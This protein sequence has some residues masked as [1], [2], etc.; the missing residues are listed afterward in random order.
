MESD[1]WTTSM[2]SSSV[3]VRRLGIGHL[4]AVE[5]V[6]GAGLEPAWVSPED[7]R[8]T[9]AFAARSLGSWSGLC[10]HRIAYRDVGAPRPVSTPSGP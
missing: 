5:E 7:F 8:T 10:L 2:N 4:P 3:H 1:D 9:S 6:P